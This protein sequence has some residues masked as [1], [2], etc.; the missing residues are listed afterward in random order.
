MPS[1][2]RSNL[3][4]HPRPWIPRW[5]LVSVKIIGRENDIMKTYITES[6][7]WIFVFILI[8]LMF[9]ATFNTCQFSIK[10]IDYLM[11]PSAWK[12]QKNL[13][14]N[15]WFERLIL[16]VSIIYLLHASDTYNLGGVLAIEVE[17]YIMSHTE[18]FVVPLQ[19]SQK[20]QSV[21]CSVFF[22]SYT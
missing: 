1:S 18:F 2:C 3:M 7:A 4:R 5:R 17:T 12:Y 22:L 15:M 14:N 11:N 21:F 13:I 9:A 10:F 16:K 6:T 20:I 19:Q 8:F